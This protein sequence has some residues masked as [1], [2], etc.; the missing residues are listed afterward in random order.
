MFRNM[1]DF[2]DSVKSKNQNETEFHQ[3]VHEV[4]E[5][6]W[7]FVSNNPQYQ[8]NAILERITEPERV[9]I[10]RVPDTGYSTKWPCEISGADPGAVPGA[11]TSFWRLMG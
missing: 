2:L 10:F 11:S 1:N 3:A 9:L 7:D 5:S 6:I 4:I 8:Y